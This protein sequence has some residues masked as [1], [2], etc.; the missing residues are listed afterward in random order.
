M[1][2]TSRLK[3]VLSAASE[4]SVPEASVAPLV[5]SL[6]ASERA[7]VCAAWALAD[8]RYP[9]VVLT[10]G[11]AA[12]DHALGAA[13]NVLEFQLDGDAIVG[14]VTHRRGVTIHRADRATVMKLDRDR[15][16]A[17]EWGKSAGASFPVDIEIEATDCTGLLRDD[18]DVLAR[19]RLDVTASR[20]VSRDA[21]ARLDFALG[22]IEFG[23]LE[24]AL[25]L[26]GNVRGV[27]R[28]ARRRQLAAAKESPQ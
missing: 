12:R 23:Q 16:V 24:R 9:D 25:A 11:E 27:T 17:A 2:N 5:G 26:V 14:F 8:A 6:S 10:D 7:H 22:V 28:A 20:A 13:S 4:M 3:L 21:A 15:R 18:S 1:V 19:N